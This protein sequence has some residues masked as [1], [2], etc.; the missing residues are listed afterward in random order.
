[1]KDGKEKDFFS[2]FISLYKDKM[3]GERILFCLL[4]YVR[5]LRRRQYVE[6]FFLLPSLSLFCWTS[7]NVFTR[8][9][10]GLGSYPPFPPPF[11]PLSATRR[12]AFP[13]L[14][15]VLAE[16]F[17]LVDVRY[18]PP[19]FLIIERDIATRC[20]KPRL[21]FFGA[22]LFIDRRWDIRTWSRWFLVFF[23]FFWF[24]SARGA[25]FC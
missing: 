8:V 22:F 18:S 3:V 24:L 25:V 9:N 5:T 12:R 19:L 10:S 21:I 16:K 13:P 23:F 14:F 6:S 7:R 20:R 11:L 4:H 17:L 15:D 2:F 1:M